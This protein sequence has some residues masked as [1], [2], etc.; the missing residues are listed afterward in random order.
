MD[1]SDT[2]WITSYLAYEGIKV[3]VQL[4]SA[5]L[6]RFVQD[7]AVTVKLPPAG[8]GFSVMNRDRVIEVSL[9]VKQITA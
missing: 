5:D 4:S 6:A 3:A 8:T 2:S 7:G 1:T 9:T